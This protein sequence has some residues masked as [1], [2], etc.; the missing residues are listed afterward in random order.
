MSATGIVL[1]CYCL[2]LLTVWFNGLVAPWVDMATM[3]NAINISVVD[4]NGM[5]T[6]CVLYC[7]TCGGCC[8]IPL[9]TPG[10]DSH[11]LESF[12]L[13][14]HSWQILYSKSRAVHFCIYLRNLIQCLMDH[15][16]FVQFAMCHR[17]RDDVRF[18]MH[19]THSQAVRAFTQDQTWWALLSYR[20][21]DFL[22]NV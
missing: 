5:F 17:N 15:R 4:V 18:L 12:G 6:L 2:G 14:Q 9:E 8:P 7:T 22:N 20:G 13:K 1:W 3:E 19:S 11:F 10:I 21:K 16:A